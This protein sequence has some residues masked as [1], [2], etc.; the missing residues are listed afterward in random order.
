MKKLDFSI[1]SDDGYKIFTSSTTAR[2]ETGKTIDFI[3]YYHLYLNADGFPI[4]GTESDSQ[5]CNIAPGD[6]F[7]IEDSINAFVNLGGSTIKAE[8]HATLY[9]K[10]ELEIGSVEAPLECNEPKLFSAEI[11]SQVVGQTVKGLL[12][13]SYYED[14]SVVTLN[15][16]V[17]LENR[18]KFDQRNIR[19]QLTLIDKKGKEIENTIA[20]GVLGANARGIFGG[21]LSLNNDKKLPGATIKVTLYVFVPVGTAISEGSAVS[22]V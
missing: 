2:N 5:W 4:E 19:L 11:E 14:S 9:A 15:V 10:E 7:V 6:E 3:S 22:E 17:L 1:Q 20:Y 13:R 16:T 8:M 12:Y 18:T 21:V